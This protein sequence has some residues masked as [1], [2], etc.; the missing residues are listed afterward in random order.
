MVSKKSKHGTI[1]IA[2]LANRWL[3]HVGA[4]IVRI[5][6]MKPMEQVPGV[7]SWTLRMEYADISRYRYEIHGALERGFLT[8]ESFAV[9]VNGKL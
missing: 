7:A 6:H 2:L 4:Y 3:L 5:V 9:G 8:S 1:S